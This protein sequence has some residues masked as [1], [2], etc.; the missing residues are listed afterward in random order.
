MNRLLAHSTAVCPVT[1]GPGGGYYDSMLMSAVT[2]SSGCCMCVC[3]CV[4]V[5]LC[6]CS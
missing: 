3:V 1:V 5:C 6:V 4:C 2:V